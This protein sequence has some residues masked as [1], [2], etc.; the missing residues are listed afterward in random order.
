MRRL[1]R[2]KRGFRKNRSNK[3]MIQSLRQI[4]NRIRSIENTRKVTNALEL[5][6]VAKYNQTERVLAASRPFFGKLESLLARCASGTIAHPL[7]EQRTARG[8][9]GVLV[10]TSDSGLCGTYNNN[11]IRCAEK[12]LC[13]YDKQAVRLVPVGRKG[14]GYFKKREYVI[15]ASYVGLNGRY[16]EDVC[17]GIGRMLERLFLSGEVDTVYAIY[18]RFITALSQKAVV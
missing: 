7:Y 13:G 14:F 3:H 9:I 17:A 10:V 11:V 16:R 8:K 15:P 2:S 6:S 4:K 5:I 12:F 18:S 1:P